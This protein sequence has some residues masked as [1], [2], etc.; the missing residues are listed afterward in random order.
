MTEKEFIE[1]IN[2]QY[3]VAPNLI[4]GDGG[5]NIKRG[6]AHSVAGYVEDL[7]ALYMAKRIDDKS[8]SFFVDKVISIRLQEGLK[9]KSFKP[10]LMILDSDNSMTHFFDLKTNLGWKRNQKH[11]LL[12]K[13][14]FIKSIRGKNAWIHRKNS[15]PII[16]KIPEILNY[17]MVVVYGQNIN[18]KTMQQ[19]LDIAENLEGVELKILYDKVDGEWMINK[20]AFKELYT[21]DSINN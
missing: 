12:E 9:A 16:V 4:E 5:Y 21:K 18:S 2:S 3:A 15:D 11:F 17:T 8:L 19:N 7:F 20:K 13:S 1:N 14:D 10:D 6:M